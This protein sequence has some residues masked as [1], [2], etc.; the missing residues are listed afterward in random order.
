[1]YFSASPHENCVLHDFVSD[2]HT[3]IWLAL[4]AC[5]FGIFRNIFI[6]FHWWE[7]NQP[8]ESVFGALSNCQN[9]LI[10]HFLFWTWWHLIW[11]GRVVGSTVILRISGAVL[12]LTLCSRPWSFQDSFHCVWSLYTGNRHRFYSSDN[13]SISPGR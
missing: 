10:G 11:V 1:M 3:S 9:G 8:E 12:S 6:N 5:C 13:C 4:N 2:T 7:I